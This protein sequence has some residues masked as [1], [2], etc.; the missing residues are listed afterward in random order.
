MK[1]L[2]V[3]TFALGVVVTLG[4]LSSVFDLPGTA[5]P[6]EAGLHNP[7]PADAFENPQNEFTDQMSIWVY[8]TSDTLGGWVC[9]VPA[10]GGNCI[11]KPTFLIGIGTT[12]GLVS[13]PIAVGNYRI[14][15]TDSVGALAGC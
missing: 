8:V 4:T 11:S 6:A 14:A 1:R 15:V 3:V 9:I 5:T 7:V 10:D 2:L 13:Q 12:Y